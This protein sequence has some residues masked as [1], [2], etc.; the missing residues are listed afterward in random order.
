MKKLAFLCFLL[1]SKTTLADDPLALS[2]VKLDTKDEYTMITNKC[3]HSINLVWFYD[4][5]CSAGCSKS[6][7]AKEYQWS[8]L[9]KANYKL[10]A[11]YAPQKVD[12]SWKGEGVP[13]CK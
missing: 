1:A 10:A 11:C 8:Q 13:A 6:L 7:G 4:G 9:F 5:Q 3:D 12:P 2:C